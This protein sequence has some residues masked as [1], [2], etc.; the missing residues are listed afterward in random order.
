M[1]TFIIAEAGVNHNGRDDLA[2]ALVDAAVLAGADAVKFQTFQAAK[3]VQK[4][5][6]KVAY[7]KES[8]GEGSQFEM[9]SRLEMSRDLHRGLVAYCGEKGIEFMSTPFDEDSA[10]FLK[11]EGMRR[12]KIPSGEITNLVFLR[13]LSGLGLPM[14]LSTGMATIEEISEA[15]DTL[16]ASWAG[17]EPFDQSLTVL[18]CTSNYPTRPENVNLRAMQTIARET[19]FPVGYSDHTLGIA[20][21]P[22]AVALG[23]V[24]IEKHFT[25]DRTMEGPDHKA[26]L[27]PHELKQ[28]IDQVRT[29]EAALGSDRKGPTDTEQEMRVMARRSIAAA[30]DLPAGTVLQACDLVMLRPA[31]GILPRDFA[32]LVGRT[33]ARPVAGG[34]TL[35]WADIV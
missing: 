3:V 35:N 20:I 32:A 19:G 12:V 26:S 10:D 7:Q 15:I 8:T 11:E 29:V 31:T 4:S 6:A 14:I 30:R 16:R 24:V 1:S 2:Y 25:L 5:T 9:L 34:D 21:C 18:H 13:H 17:L 33:M 28:M 22:A 27:E 23:A